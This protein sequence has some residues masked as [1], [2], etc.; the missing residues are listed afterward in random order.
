LDIESPAGV[1][2]RD[3]SAPIGHQ[4]DAP[5]GGH[6]DS[7]LRSYLVCS[8][9][10]SGS[11]LL[12]RALASTGLAGTPTEYFNPVN[13][14]TLAARWGCAADL[15][16][17][18]AA[19]YAR[20]TSSD[21]VFGTK[22]HWEQF[23]Q[24]RAEALGLGRA[25]PEFEISAKPLEELFPA[26][27]YIHVMR[28]DVNRQAIS[29]WT[30]LQTGVWSRSA[31][32]MHEPPPAP[33]SFDG[34][35]RCRRLIENAELHWDRFFRFNG[36]EPLDVVYEE[37]DSAYEDTVAEVVRYLV[38]EAGGVEVGPP[39]SARQG[40]AHS[41]TL[42]ERFAEEREIRGL[43]DPLALP[44]VPAARPARTARASLSICMIT[45]DPPGRVAAALKAVRPM[46]DEVVIAADSR[47][48]EQTLAGYAAPCD[49]LLRV[50]YVHS[51]RHLAWLYS[52][53]DGDWILRLDGD[54][55]PSAALTARLPELLSTRAVQ[56]YW[57][58][59]A[60]LHPDPGHVLESAPWSEDFVNRLTRNDGT[61]RIRGQ[62]HSDVD[63]VTPREYIDEPLYHLDLL[64]SS[65]RQ[66]LDKAVHYEALRPGLTAAGGRGLNEAF[67]L[68]EMRGTLELRTVPDEDRD[69]I[70]RAFDDGRSERGAP[71]PAGVPFVALAEMDRLWE[72]RTVSP[73]AYRARIDPLQPTIE[74]APGERREVF[75]RVR[76]DGE[77]RWAA[78]LEESPQ[79]RLAYRWLNPDQSVHTAE[80][81]R[82]AFPRMVGP[83]E[84]ILAPL[85]V[86]APVEP[87][88]YLLEVDVVHE[89][90]RWFDCASR[91]PARVGDAHRR[92]A[93]AALLVETERPRLKR[94]R[95]SRIPRTIH[96]VWLGG[97][98][99]D[100]HERFGETFA[101][102]H[103]GWEMRLWGEADL[104]ALEI[105]AG[106][107][108]RARTHSEL[109]NL[110]RY[111]VLHRYGGVY[112]DTDVEC[113]R[114]FTPL[115]RGIEG[116]AALET[117]GRVGTAILGAAPGH[118]TFERAARLTRR[119]LGSGV[120]S[121]DANGPG[122]LS[123]ILEQEPSLA[124]FPACLFYPYLWNQ[125]ER[126]HEA[127]PRAYAVHHWTLSW[128]EGR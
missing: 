58:R 50:D 126:R 47:V 71:A 86:E 123:L 52:Q 40:G 65:E 6:P 100:E 37:L 10:R 109:S 16:S 90:T 73:A 113:R 23:E 112:V 59:R 85:L 2:V 106:E 98:I 116:F 79:I 12:C 108:A 128:L 102:H 25:Q 11:G 29:F 96:R 119:T 9:P 26:P 53:C 20:R 61:V 32:D 127:F 35:D 18:L 97:A 114:P 45:A 48:D 103:P 24:L 110:V 92:F 41:A 70:A 14:A 63:P 55:I 122:L 21:G 4:H 34:I 124:I 91:L 7:A 31:A 74:L 66:R 42:L 5:A 111:E 33:Y 1:T 104:A 57:I 125:P 8:T 39:E 44:D 15:R 17:Y 75:V 38:P 78:R 82:S 68:P 118:P 107:R 49:R 121:P 28:R 101:E 36:I 51:E 83:G 43:D 64:T 72:G 54:E 88:S 46:A 94:W 115:L 81:H 105:D 87:G 76:N 56:Q 93:G 30:A 3:L 60:W 69:A 77:E 19:L 89:H 13:R 27:L 99:P 95:R 120:H 62:Q 117:P 84:S 80:G 22:L 67:Y